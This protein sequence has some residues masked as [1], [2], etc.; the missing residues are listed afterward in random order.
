MVDRHGYAP[1]LSHCKCD[2]LLLSLQ[3]QMVHT[4][5][6]EPTVSVTVGLQPT[7][8]PLVRRMH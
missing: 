2:V 6:I 7:G 5:G 4:V 1:W 3:A 8:L